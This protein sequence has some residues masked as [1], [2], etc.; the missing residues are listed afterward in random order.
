MRNAINILEGRHDGI[1]EVFELHRPRVF[2]I[3]HRMLRMRTEAED[4]VQDAYL[5]WHQSAKQDIQS[6]VAFLVTITRRLCLDRLR[7]L[8]Q[9]R[10]HYV[11]PWRPELI[12][13]D[14]MPSPETRCELV[15]EVS[16]AFLAV[17][18]RLGSEERA[19]FLLHEVFDYDY[20]EVAQ[21]IGKSESTCRQMV[22]RARPR[23]RES[24]PRFAV[25]VES[26]KRL[27]EKFFAAV[28]TGDR[29]AVMALLAEDIDYMADAGGKVIADP[30][31]GQQNKHL[32][33]S[34]VSKDY[35]MEAPGGLLPGPRPGYK[36]PP[37]QRRRQHLSI[38]DLLQQ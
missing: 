25:T 33:C 29:Q 37:G 21:M 27:L 18:E 5:R 32:A 10:E 14:D 8:N 35:P 17:L 31:I 13:E 23:A 11:G 3:A 9:E 26:R 1:A 22:H 16:I 19:A 4:I 24:R 6:P 38:G 28:G 15:D 34:K 12:V 30:R 7:E 36:Q 20:P 2:G